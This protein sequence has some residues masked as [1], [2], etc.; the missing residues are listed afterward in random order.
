MSR[1]NLNRRHL[2]F[3]ARESLARA[4][5]LQDAAQALR[6]RT[7]GKAE[8]R[9][10]SSA[11]AVAAKR[12]PAETIQAEAKEAETIQSEPPARS[13]SASLNAL[14]SPTLHMKRAAAPLPPLSPIHANSKGLALRQ[15]VSEKVRQ[16]LTTLSITPRPDREAGY[17][18]TWNRTLPGLGLTPER[19]TAFRETPPG[20]G[21][22]VEAVLAGKGATLG[23][24]NSGSPL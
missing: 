6:R 5:Q 12:A 17:I 8:A 24:P 21:V 1:K 16:F 9:R 2:N 18:S 7:R 10:V 14:P 11:R 22:L 15:E 4:R 13:R 19:L 3:L 23:P 20:P